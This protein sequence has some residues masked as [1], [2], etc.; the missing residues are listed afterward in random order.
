MPYLLYHIIIIK[1]FILPD[2]PNYFQ[3][4]NRNNNARSGN[5]V[6]KGAV[7]EALAV[8]MDLVETVDVLDSRWAL[9]KL[10]MQIVWNW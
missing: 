4:M 6:N 2:F 7:Q 8:G 9:F 5:I 3:N 10:P 1:Q